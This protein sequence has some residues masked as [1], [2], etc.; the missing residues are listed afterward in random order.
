MVVTKAPVLKYALCRTKTKHR[1]SCLATMILPRALHTLPLAS[2]GVSDAH[3]IL[4]RL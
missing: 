1:D 4:G 2:R 3:V